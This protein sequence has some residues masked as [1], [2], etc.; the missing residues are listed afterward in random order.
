MSR[1]VPNRAAATTASRQWPGLRGG[2]RVLLTKNAVTS[3]GSTG[4]C[5]SNFSKRI[6]SNNS[7]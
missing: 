6:S 4:N 5:L 2:E 7:N 1:P 3:N